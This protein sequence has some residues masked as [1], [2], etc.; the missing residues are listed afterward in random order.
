MKNKKV[1]SSILAL[2]L[3][4][5]SLYSSNNI[6]YSISYANTED[7]VVEKNN[8]NVD[9]SLKLYSNSGEVLS[10]TIK[11]G[12]I[13]ATGLNAGGRYVG[14]DL[15]LEI[16][17]STNGN[18]IKSIV[19]TNENTNDFVNQINGV[20]VEKNNILHISFN[21]KSGLNS[22]NIVSNTG[23]NS[24]VEKI[25]N[26][27]YFFSIKDGLII[28]CSTNITAE[29][30]N[31]GSDDKFI[32][33]KGKA[34]P[35]SKVYIRYDD[36]IVET[37]VNSA[38]IYECKI[39]SD[40][41]FRGIK[42]IYISY[43]DGVSIAEDVNIS[44]SN[45]Y[46]T[47]KN[48]WNGIAAIMTFDY[49]TMK[50]GVEQKSGMFSNSG[51][52]FSMMLIGSNPL[53][54]YR[55]DQKSTNVIDFV[56]SFNDRSFKIGDVFGLEVSNSINRNFTISNNGNN[57]SLPANTRVYYKIT[58][59]GLEPYTDYIRVNPLKVISSYNVKN[60]NITGETFPNSDVEIL[61]NNT[62]SYKVRSNA[63]GIFSTTINTS[64]PISLN[65]PIEIRVGEYYKIVYPEVSEESGLNFKTVTGYEYTIN[66]DI[67]KIK[68][69]FPHELMYGYQILSE[70]AKK[71]WDIAVDSIM[72]A[73]EYKKH[74]NKVDYYIDVFYPDL[75]ITWEDEHHIIAYL[76]RNDPRM[77]LLKDWPPEPII[78]NG[79][80]VGQRFAIGNGVDSPE[81]YNKQLLEV[82]KGIAPI[83]ATI[84]ENMDVY[85]IAKSIQTN[86]EKSVGYENTGSCSD[87]R[88]AF[89][90]KKIICGGYS[91]ALEYL[92]LRV[93]IENIWVNGYAGG[94]HAWNNINIYNNWYLSD[95]TWG[96]E[97]WFLRGDDNDFVKNH[98][99]YDTYYKMPTLADK[100]I[101]WNTSSYP[102]TAVN[103][104]GIVN[105]ENKK[106]E[107]T[108]TYDVSNSDV[109]NS[110]VEILTDFNSY[111]PIGM[112]ENNG[113]WSITFNYDDVKKAKNLSNDYNKNI[114]FNFYFR[115]NNLYNT[116]GN[117]V[118]NNLHT[119]LFEN[120]MLNIVSSISKKNSIPWTDI[121]GIPDVKIK[122][123][124]IYKGEV[125][126]PSM[127]IEGSI[128]KAKIEV[129]KN[130]D[131][132][133]IGSQ[134]LE[135]KIIFENGSSVKKV[136]PVDVIKNPNDDKTSGSGN[137]GSTG[138][139]G[140]GTTSGS[141]NI[142]STNSEKNNSNKKNDYNISIRRI[143]GDSRY[144]T[145]VNIAKN[146]YTGNVD[147]I[148]L[149]NSKKYADI[150]SS[151]PVANK[152]NAPI[153][154]T[155]Y[156]K[157]PHEVFE[158]IKNKSVKNIILIGGKDSISERQK[159]Y[160]EKSNLKV[161]RISG[162]NRY[163]TSINLNK[164]FLDNTGKIEEVIITSGQNYSDA[165]S[166]T[167]Y[168]IKNKLPI[169]ITD[170]RILDS[171]IKDILSKN[172][173]IKA[174]VIG[175]KN[176]ISDEVV[177]ELNR[178]TNNIKRISG[179]DRYSTAVEISK[180]IMKPIDRKAFLANGEEYV[181]SLIGSQIAG[182]EGL[183]ILLTK[184]AG[185]PNCT[186]EYIQSNIGNITIIGGEKT[187]PSSQIK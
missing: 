72:N 8:I 77:F 117:V 48:I 37:D 139:E 10:L 79:K 2:T 112:V 31:I 120:G 147:T 123:I 89:I 114:D 148:M 49:N 53:D 76:V 87:I 154:Y 133:K 11:N 52:L 57:I 107:V 3:V 64:T 39:T 67:D 86:F 71:A 32:I 100:S 84:N 165:L 24:P 27:G 103:N 167:P 22:V 51:D 134:N 105:V 106:G 18:V 180:N 41:G 181:D 66:A 30:I 137:T 126:D 160:L 56:N 80:I 119:K 63:E 14:D 15:K 28:P 91:K 153:L 138:Q 115:V 169:F 26:N 81:T 140:S 21:E 174:Y 136:I 58:K 55:Y 9:N 38:G 73:T 19:S 25:Y 175:G 144:S 158:F 162:K 60:F 185:M 121:V 187:I 152:L 50:I 125:V 69:P 5:S 88:G 98:K 70:D 75:N 93:G 40:I 159:D 132:Q 173:G 171:S 116:A 29:K 109:K 156:N 176:S 172:S 184:Y 95:S 142:G 34:D 163:D 113:I 104:T 178:Y 170:G 92:L 145:S 129:L 110:N 20:L 43:R 157:I 168:A 166:I 131:N 124:S 42:K 143:G 1:I 78:K 65:T 102:T 97:N 83:L 183:P 151:V 96:G 128:G 17:D 161:E 135:I 82:E 61:V 94:P 44:A 16:I 179:S 68:Q 33:V 6:F 7:S 62:E 13:E 74:S 130:I 141:G 45:P 59:S 155:E 111:K 149:V 177:L 164:I 150:L 54:I 118:K 101:P 46:I 23:N 146:L 12:R 122:K 36:N 4:T 35:N 127:G 182:K 99:V 90:N 108:I 85:Q 186:Y 47:I